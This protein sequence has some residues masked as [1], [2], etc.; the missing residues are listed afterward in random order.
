MSGLATSNYPA[1]SGLDSSDFPGTVPED[2]R[3]WPAQDIQA[4]HHLMNHARWE[5]VG[6][7]SGIACSHIAIVMPLHP[8]VCFI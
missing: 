7:A 8:G 4:V 2:F 1:I 6:H 5:A 3:G